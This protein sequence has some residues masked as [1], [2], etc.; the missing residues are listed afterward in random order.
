VSKKCDACQSEEDGDCTG[1]FVHTCDLRPITA[2]EREVVN[3]ALSFKWGELRMIRP[4]SG[5]R[6]WSACCALR[7]AR[8]SK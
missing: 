2:E 8:A 4:E 3:A 1:Y 7:E 6:L 5:N